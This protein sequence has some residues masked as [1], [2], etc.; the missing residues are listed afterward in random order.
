LL[1]A[2]AVDVAVIFLLLVYRRESFAVGHAVVPESPGYGIHPGQRD[3]DVPVYPGET[4]PRKW[5]AAWSGSGAA[6]S[7]MFS[8][9][10]LHYSCTV[11]FTAPCFSGRCVVHL[12]LLLH[13]V[14]FGEVAL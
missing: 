4:M 8:C 9:E 6:F 3:K 11:P 2:S 5:H 14:G 10:P 7:T 13:H 12:V 1:T